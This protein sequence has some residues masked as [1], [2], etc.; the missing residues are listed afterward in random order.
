MKWISKSSWKN[1]VYEKTMVNLKSFI[2][3]EKHFNVIFHELF[4]VAVYLPGN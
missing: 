1:D 3:K 2:P 4:K